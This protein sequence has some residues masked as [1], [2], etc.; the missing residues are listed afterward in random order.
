MVRHRVTLIR[1][2]SG[3]NNV[4]LAS[5]PDNWYVVV[6]LSQ[7]SL[8]LLPLLPPT[9]SVPTPLLFSNPTLFFIQAWSDL[10]EH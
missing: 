6:F 3:T 5:S 1:L 4:K 7:A 10:V 2:R 9:L 8:R